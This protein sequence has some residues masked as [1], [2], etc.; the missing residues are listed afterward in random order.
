MPAYATGMKAFYQPVKALTLIL[1][2][3]W[4]IRP[5]GGIPLIP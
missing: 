1:V 4:E 5:K 2:K 3:S